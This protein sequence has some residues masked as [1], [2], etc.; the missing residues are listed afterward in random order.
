MQNNIK[1]IEAE[2]AAAL[3]FLASQTKFGINLGLG[4][5]TRL[6]ELLGNPHRQGVKYIHIGGTNGKGSVSAFVAAGLRAAGYK[7][8][9]FNSPHLHSYR[10]RYVIDGEMISREELVRYIGMLK[11]V[12]A[13]MQAEGAE[14]PT[15]FELSTA[16]ALRYF[17]DEQ[18]DYAV[19]EVG[20]GGAID[21]TNVI[22]PEVALITNVAIDH[23]DYLGHTV[24][25]IAAVKAGIIKPGVPVFTAAK[26]PDAIAEIAKA[27]EKCGSRLGLIGRDFDYEKAASDES[28][29]RF[30]FLDMSGNQDMSKNN[31]AENEKIPDLKISML[32]RHQLANAALAV[33]GMRE[34]GLS[35]DAIRAGLEAARWPG[36]LEIISRDPL[37]LIDGAHNVA[38]MQALSAALREYWPGRS[39]VAVLGMLADKEREKALGELLPL[40]SEVIVTRV[41]SYRAGDWEALAEVCRAAGV[42][43]R[44]VES[45]TEAVEVGRSALRPGQML[46]VSGSLYMLAEARAYLLGI[47]PDV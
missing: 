13:Q 14:Q 34:I 32:G 37:I 29:Q 39:I 15:E 43:C 23:M 41:P 1:N 40:L 38:G 17:S 45:V 2:Y 26:D 27:A 25:E 24:A 42:P 47:G 11:P 4:R 10:E 33:A 7:T 28:G 46:L 35:C 16:L 19:I 9:V 5:I 6:L 44:T 22:V 30:D 12:L 31:V 3:E 21:S 8:A 36:R 18:V 20:M